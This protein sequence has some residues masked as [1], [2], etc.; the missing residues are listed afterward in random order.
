VALSRSRTVAAIVLI[1]AL[2]LGFGSS[3]VLAPEANALV[4]VSALTVVDG[5]VLIGQG[6]AD[7]RPGQAGDVL[8]AGDRIRTGT[9]AVAEITYFEGSTVRLE[10]DTEIVVES[11]G[12]AAD[13]G[14]VVAMMQTLGRTWHVVTKLVSG[15][16][17]YEVRTPSSTASVRGTIFAVDV[18]VD[19]D[20][21]SATVTTSEGV[22]VHTA[23]DPKTG[24]RTQVRV[25]AGQES[26]KS[27]SKPAEA[28]HPASP[29]TLREAPA[30]SGSNRGP[31]KSA[32]PS[33]D[34]AELRSTVRAGESALVAT[35]P[36]DRA[37]SSRIPRSQPQEG[38]GR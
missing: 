25:S 15:S 2:A 9:G 32:R 17:R 22:V 10:A 5:A 38:R 37:K 36:K 16:S 30:R 29:A 31:T 21:P 3:A 13:G 23:A 19:T 20:G 12:T 33:S 1:V 26:T 11:L 4:S 28:A 27:A 24:D 34:R 7:F 14:T 18:R 6:G 35:Q 8:I